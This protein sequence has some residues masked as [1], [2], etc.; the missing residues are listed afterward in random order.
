MA[1]DYRLENKTNLKT[2]NL[3][4][5]DRWVVKDHT[6]PKTVN[7]ERLDQWVL[8]DHTKPRDIK[9]TLPVG[10]GTWDHGALYNRD[11]EDQ[12]PITAIT[13]LEYV[14]EQKVERTE[15]AAVAFSGDINDLTSEM[16]ALI[17]CG[18]STEVI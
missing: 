2:I 9:I 11:R 8:K 17:Y 4:K 12:H 15:L 13:G 6:K 16:P 5:T 10:A 18:T 1:E 14:L 7:L 3:E